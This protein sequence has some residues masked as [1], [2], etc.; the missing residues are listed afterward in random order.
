MREEAGDPGDANLWAAGDMMFRVSGGPEPDRLVKVRR[1]YALVGRAPDAD[2]LVNDQAV[3][4]RHAYLHLDPRGVYVVDLVT[5]TGTRLNGT[6]RMVGWL[7]PG[8]WIEVAGRRLELLR[9]RV[10][11][12]VVDPPTRLDE[13]LADEGRGDLV[14]VTLE[15][16][17]SDDPPWVLGSELV[18]IGWSASC[19]IQV[20][21]DAVSRTHCAL[22]RT[23][24][25]AY[26][27]NLSVRQTW[28]ED[29]PVT[30]AT[31]LRDG[32]LITLGSTQFT[33]LVDHPA[34]P[35]TRTPAAAH[36]PRPE[37]GTLLARVE[38]P[39]GAGPAPLPV[40]PPF[41]LNPELVPVDA[42]N[43]IL[44][45]VMGTIQGGQ[46]E[47]FRRQGEFQHAI[48]QALRQIQQDSA[49]LLNAHL[50]RIE[51]IDRELTA[52]RAEIGR[53]NA[54]A[55]RTPPL[56]H[57]P[58]LKIRP[59]A[60]PDPGARASQASTAWLLQRVGQLE[61]ENRSAWKDLLGKMDAPK[62][63]G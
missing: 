63:P 20:R 57:V 60:P 45:W 6:D 36:A 15:T 40:R 37:T 49:T 42:Q 41:A 5:R 25:A 11:G 19:G 48:T 26:L 39:D 2:L 50:Q 35:R 8:D 1:P 47:V 61:D 31:A 30:G 52:L 13:M 10:D 4:A 24:D 9:I 21:D 56:P 51:N 7:R 14:P 46:V 38:T 44:A 22:V 34:R 12:A 3:S 32:D 29:R 55:P 28:V 58:P 27:V 59:Q 18:V 43:A 33:A 53:R 62:P 54:D 16:Q 17:R 23:T